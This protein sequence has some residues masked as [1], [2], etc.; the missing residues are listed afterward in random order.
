MNQIHLELYP[1][2]QIIHIFLRAIMLLSPTVKN[3]TSNKSVK[4]NLE[5]ILVE[6]FYIKQ[7]KKNQ[8][9]CSCNSVFNYFFCLNI[10]K[11]HLI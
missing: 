8:N 2:L 5:L 4:N 6:F 11:S 10:K 3:D 7:A 1:N 9:F